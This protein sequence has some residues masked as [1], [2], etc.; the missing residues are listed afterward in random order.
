MSLTPTCRVDRARRQ[1][2]DD[3]LDCNAEQSWMPD[4]AFRSGKLRPRDAQRRPDGQ[5]VRPFAEVAAALLARLRVN[6]GSRRSS[7]NA[8]TGVIIRNGS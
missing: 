7:K 2:V 6:V 4:P 3:F 8:A 1:I 5:H